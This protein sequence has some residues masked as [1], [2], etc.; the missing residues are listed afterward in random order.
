MCGPA[1]GIVF[2]FGFHA[3]FTLRWLS[4]D[5]F[6]F[7]CLKCHSVTF[8]RLR[9]LVACERG[10]WQI[11]ST[12]LRRGADPNKHDG[13][14]VPLFLASK[15]GADDIVR[16]LISHSADVNVECDSSCENTPLTAAI[17]AV[18]TS[19]IK[20]L[21][22]NGANPNVVSSL[23]NSI[24]VA[25]QYGRH[26]CMD[27]LLKHGASLE[28]MEIDFP[29]PLEYAAASGSVETVKFLLTQGLDVNEKNCLRP[30]K[31]DAMLPANT[32]DLTYPIVLISQPE[33]HFNYNHTSYGS[34]INAAAAYGHTDVVKLLV[35]NNA[36]VNKRSH[37]WET[38]STLAKLRGH[39]VTLEYLVSKGG[40]AL[41]Q[42]EVCY[43]QDLF[44]GSGISNQG[45]R[46]C[47]DHRRRRHRRH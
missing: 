24:S 33:P 41:E 34:P 25:A 31:V 35:E 21:L 7:A 11:A 23:G 39:E 4:R 15:H 27:L 36:A 9:A 37:Y 12:L 44:K 8:P 45:L 38:P 28:E 16:E 17:V 18:H 46:F 20:L 40:V 6:V 13:M 43:R 22:I 1:A 32:Y 2:F 19:T 47:G 3:V 30:L 10:H 5:F 14:T 42:I 29:S 26:E